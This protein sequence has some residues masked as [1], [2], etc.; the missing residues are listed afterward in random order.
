M[1]GTTEYIILYLICIFGCLVLL[2]MSW[3]RELHYCV[4]CKHS[5]IDGLGNM[6]CRTR[7]MYRYDTGERVYWT[8]CLRNRD[9]CC[10]YYKEK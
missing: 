9:G 5:F 8:C 3:Q 7:S 4:N 1:I 10:R 2:Y 6:K